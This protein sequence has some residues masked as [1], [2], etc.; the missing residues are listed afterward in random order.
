MDVHLIELA[1]KIFS[2]D[3]VAISDEK[4]RGGIPGKGRDNLPNSPF[5]SWVFGHVEM[6]VTPPIMS[7]ND[8]NKQHAKADGWHAKK[9]T[10]AR[11]RT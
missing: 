9:S 11:S 5:R 3:A 2:I 6:D 10:A 8:K 7:Q 1:T 4:S